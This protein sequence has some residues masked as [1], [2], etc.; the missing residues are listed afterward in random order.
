MSMSQ[1]VSLLNRMY[2][3]FNG[4]DIDGVLSIMHANVEW[5]NG[6]EGGYVVGRDSVRDYWTRQW[7]AINPTVLPEGFEVLP[8]R[9][10][11]VRVHQ[12]VLDLGG[13]L[14]SDKMVSHTYTFE[15]GLIRAMNIGEL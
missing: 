12:R 2:D 15:E 8:D 7:A 14:L 3:Q 9:R 6:W 13:K 11:K 1:E 10:I 5:P 4:R